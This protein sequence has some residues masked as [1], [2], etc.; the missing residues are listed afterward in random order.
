MNI[1][2]YI[3]AIVLISLFQLFQ[4]GLSLWQMVYGWSDPEKIQRNKFPSTY[5]APQILFSIII[6][7]RHEVGVIGMTLEKIVQQKYPKECFEV[8]VVIAHD[9]HKTIEEVQE[10]I[11]K[12]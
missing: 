7:C 9:D 1:D 5:E 11:H 4:G 12:H 2:P 6:P 8:L 3:T 10:T